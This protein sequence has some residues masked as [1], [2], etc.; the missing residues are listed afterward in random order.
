MQFQQWDFLVFWR[1]VALWF[2]CLRE[3]ECE[4]DHGGGALGK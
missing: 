3:V 2:V 4:L 1:G